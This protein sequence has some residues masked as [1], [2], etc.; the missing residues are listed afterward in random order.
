MCCNLV[1]P[2]NPFRTAIPFWGQLTWDL[3]DLSPKRD[4]GPK[5][6]ERQGGRVEETIDKLVSLS[7]ATQKSLQ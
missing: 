1:P 5:R 7:C 2:V 3:S 6:V 4:G